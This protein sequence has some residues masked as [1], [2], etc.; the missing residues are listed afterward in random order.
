MDYPPQMWLSLKQI[1]VAES[2]KITVYWLLDSQWST[3]VDFTSLKMRSL[4]KGCIEK[5]ANHFGEGGQC[6]PHYLIVWQRGWGRSSS[7]LWR[8]LLGK[9]YNQR[10][11]RFPSRPGDKEMLSEESGSVEGCGEQELV[12]N[13][14]RRKVV[15]DVVSGD[16]SQ[17]RRG[18]G[19]IYLLDCGWPKVTGISSM[20]DW[21]S[22]RFSLALISEAQVFR[23]S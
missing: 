6:Q 4:S 10:P 8:G 17:E 3:E 14:V 7:F 20:E 15:Q 16:R 1:A 12:Q 11:R 5:S 2:V 9:P 18:T 13:R 21:G 23:A 22:C 19:G